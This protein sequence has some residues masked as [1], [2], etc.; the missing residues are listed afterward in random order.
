MR[1]YNPNRRVAEIVLAPHTD[2]EATRMLSGATD[3]WAFLR[4]YERLRQE[5][6]GVEQA[7]VF[8]GHLFGMRHPRHQPVGQRKASARRAV[9]GAS[10]L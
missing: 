5:G 6:M 1:W 7:L 4:E 3:S 10:F 9:E 2:E 8:V